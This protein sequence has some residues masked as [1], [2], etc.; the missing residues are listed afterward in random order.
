M[1]VSKGYNL[2]ALAPIMEN[3]RLILLS[4]SYGLDSEDGLFQSVART[5]RFPNSIR[6]IACGSRSNVN[7]LIRTT[8]P[9]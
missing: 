7:S 8:S 1:A 5:W 4:D 2:A 6:A 9:G 3:G